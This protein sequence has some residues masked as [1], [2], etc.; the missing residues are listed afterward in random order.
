LTGGVGR[1]SLSGGDG[2]DIFKYNH[3]TEA[4]IVSAGAAHDLIRDFNPTQGDRID[5][6]QIDARSGNKTNDSFTFLNVAPTTNGSGSNGA[7]WFRGGFLYGS[8]DAD[9]SPEFQIQIF[10]SSTITAS[11]IIL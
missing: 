3:V 9:A 10:G 11:N 5:L 7:L 6:S 4:D 1:D 2:A 8:N